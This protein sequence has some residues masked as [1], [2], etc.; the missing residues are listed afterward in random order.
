MNST[1][2]VVNN[3]ERW[4]NR[5]WE[6]G[7][8]LLVAAAV[9][10]RWQ[11]S[12]QLTSLSPP[13]SVLLLPAWHDDFDNDMHVLTVSWSLLKMAS[14]P[15]VGV[16]CLFTFWSCCCC[17]Q[18]FTVFSGIPK[19]RHQPASWGHTIG[20]LHHSG[21]GNLCS[22][23][24]SCV[25]D[26]LIYLFMICEMVHC[27]WQ[28]EENDVLWLVVTIWVS[29]RRPMGFE[30]RHFWW[31]TARIL[32]W[33]NCMQNRARDGKTFFTE[34]MSFFL[35]WKEETYLLRRGVALFN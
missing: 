19:L 27:D 4:G 11:L 3:T 2:T 22:H 8:R 34:N 32:K 15:S 31:G 5:K 21:L 9:H 30:Q 14:C 20:W 23:W 28:F 25:G 29:S 18:S 16:S 33:T 6:P 1:A 24:L 12:Q 7:F 13:L 26:W 10:F 35:L 17:W